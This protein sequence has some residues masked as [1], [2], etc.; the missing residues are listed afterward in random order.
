MR[1]LSKKKLILI[2]LLI[3]NIISSQT[4]EIRNMRCSQANRKF[5]GYKCVKENKIGSG[6]SGVVFQLK[7]VN[8]SQLYILKAQDSASKK[9]EKNK[10][11][12]YLIKLNDIPGVIHLEDYKFEDDILYEILEMGELGDLKKNLRSNYF[13]DQKNIVKVFK[14]LIEA[15]DDIHSE[16]V[17]HADIKSDNI[18]LKSDYTPKIIDFDLSVP[19]GAKKG[20]RGTIPYMDPLILESWGKYYIRYN[21]SIDIYSLGIVLYEMVNKKVPFEGTI[22]SVYFAQ[23]L[24]SYIIPQGTLRILAILIEGCL[25][26]SLR[27]RFNSE[28]I[29]DYIYDFNSK[30]SNSDVLQDDVDIDMNQKIFS[31]DEDDSESINEVKVDRNKGENV[32]FFLVIC[33]VAIFG[34]LG[35]IFYRIWQNDMKE[36]VS[37]QTMEIAIVKDEE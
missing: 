6:A 26:R 30:G 32:V 29:L 22:S 12:S 1:F 21:P 8:T 37:Q 34:I 13:N 27:K 2:L 3:T 10:D 17:V 18:V 4:P 24:E 25:Q 36:D 19:L 7:K 15:I 9:I 14:K 20:G 23:K 5:E 16:D 11:L 28:K 33:L 31:H 35:V